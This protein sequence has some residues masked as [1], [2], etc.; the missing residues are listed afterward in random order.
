MSLGDPCWE[1]SGTERATGLSYQQGLKSR[2]A[3]EYSLLRKWALKY[4]QGFELIALQIPL[5]PDD[6]HHLHLSPDEYLLGIGQGLGRQS[7]ARE[8]HRRITV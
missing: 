6:H 8:L 2:S 4:V 5:L 3:I 1:S 7:G